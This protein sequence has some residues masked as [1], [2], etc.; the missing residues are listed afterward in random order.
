M[1]H[2]Q[3]IRLAFLFTFVFLDFDLVVLYWRMASGD[4]KN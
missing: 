2:D 4:C 3:L 1:Y